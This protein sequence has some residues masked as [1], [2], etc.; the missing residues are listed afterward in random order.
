M[1]GESQTLL[2]LSNQLRRRDAELKQHYID[3]KRLEHKVSEMK[4]AMEALQDTITREG[5]GA[6]PC[7]TTAD[8]EPDS[9]SGPLRLVHWLPAGAA[10]ILFVLSLAIFARYTATAEHA[11]DVAQKSA[12]DVVEYS[13]TISETAG[14]AAE[15]A[16]AAENSGRTAE[17]ASGAAKRSADDAA[18]FAEMAKVREIRMGDKSISNVLS[19]KIKK[20]LI[21][22]ETLTPTGR[23][24]TQHDLKKIV[25]CIR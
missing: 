18:T 15:S 12:V 10:A 20:C 1:N 7:E 6:V 19:R 22:V 5:E 4:R 3:F 14:K 8:R 25:T 9:R 23:L 24:L 13:Q 17:E 16:A 11:A 2:H 21:D